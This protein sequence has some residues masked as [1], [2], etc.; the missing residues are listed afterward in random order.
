V[1]KTGAK[2]VTAQG[3]DRGKRECYWE[4]QGAPRDAKKK[5][6]SVS[7]ENASRAREIRLRGTGQSVVEGKRIVQKKIKKNGVGIIE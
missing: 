2:W 3:E 7:T 1:S 4:N 5:P 6:K